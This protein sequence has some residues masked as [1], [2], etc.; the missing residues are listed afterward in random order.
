VLFDVI[1]IK[2]N[3]ES[4]LGIVHAYLMTLDIRGFIYKEFLEFVANHN[5][6]ILFSYL[7]SVIMK[8]EYNSTRIFIGFYE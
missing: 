2:Y 3:E 7:E 4:S 8:V 6:V 1:L 5:I